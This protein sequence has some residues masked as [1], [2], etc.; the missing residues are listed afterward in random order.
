MV[1]T[2]T[3]RDLASLEAGVASAGGDV[4]VLLDSALPPVPLAA[5]RAAIGPLA[6]EQAPTRRIN[7]VA[8]DTGAHPDDVAA[9]CAWLADATSTTGQVIEISARG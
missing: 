9:A 4:T 2:I 3:P 5:M 1:A 7:A 6:V 8:A